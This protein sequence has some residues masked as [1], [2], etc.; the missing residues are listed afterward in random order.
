MTVLVVEDDD[1]QRELWVYLLRRAGHRPIGAAS[2]REARAAAAAG[3]DV[4]LCDFSLPDGDAFDVQLSYMETPLVVISGRPAPAGYPGPWLE[5]P[6]T[7]EQVQH[8]LHT[9]GGAA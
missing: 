4:V 3:P 9:R 1:S 6:V 7:W 8:E 5:K 2:V